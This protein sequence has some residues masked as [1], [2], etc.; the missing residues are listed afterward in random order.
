MEAQEVVF[1]EPVVEA[2]AQTTALAKAEPVNKAVAAPRAETAAML[3][4]IE[5][6]MTDPNAS[7]ERAT[8]AFEFYQR[9][10]AEAARK[11]YYEAKAAF[12][13]NAPAV[14]KDKDNKQ[15]NSRYATIG[16]VVNTLN[17]AL[18]KFGLDASWGFDQSERIKVTCT[19]RHTLGHS[20]S[21]SL[22]G[23]PDTSGS[24]NPMQQIKSTLTYLKLATFEGVTGIATKEGN[25]DDDGNSSGNG[26]DPL[27]TIDEKQQAEIKK[28][29]ADTGSDTGRFL[30]WAGAEMVSDILVSKY[31]EAVKMLNAKKKGG[32]K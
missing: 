14:V 1:D 11:A 23:P 24:K 17:E 16:N 31:P 28:L 8:Q 5:R 26:V 30:A 32:S 3:S 18:S 6:I 29:L 21:V 27:A 25:V 9:V 10:Q 13:A 15:Y 22:S 20:E 7:M 4:M 19:L 2:N 12:K